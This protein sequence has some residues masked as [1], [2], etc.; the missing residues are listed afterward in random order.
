MIPLPLKDNWSTT[1]LPTRIGGGRTGTIHLDQVRIAG[2]MKIKY[3]AEAQG[4]TGADQGVVI[5][6]GVGRVEEEA[7]VSGG[8]ISIGT[9][10]ADVRSSGGT[11]GYRD[12]LPVIE[13]GAPEGVA[14][15]E[16]FM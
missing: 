7:T 16:Q 3:A 11:L 14:M 5:G 4:C 8:G 10:G 9:W 12:E 1:M 2:V 13:A 15:P 6:I